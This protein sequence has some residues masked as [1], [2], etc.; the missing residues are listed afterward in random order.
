[1]RSVRLLGLVSVVAVTASL[2]LA[3]PAWAIPG[4]TTGGHNPCASGV[5]GLAAGFCL[6][7]SE[8]V[9]E[10]GTKNCP[11]FRDGR[12]WQDTTDL[13]NVP[14]RWTY[15]NGN[16]PCLRVDYQ[17]V[18]TYDVC[19]FVFY[20]PWGPTAKSST[21]LVVFHWQTV[22]GT[23]HTSTVNEA[24]VR[25]WQTAFTSGMAV[26]AIYFTDA[27]GRGP[28]TSEEIAWNRG[29][30]SVPASSYGIWQFCEQA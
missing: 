17:P 11:A 12:Q 3:T 28:T 6:A 25:G 7:P 27:N 22:D 14:E 24:P 10:T 5:D 20:V 2:L 9:L 4:P 23:W 26:R 8:L 18:T 19:D 21:S 30:S 15:P 13:W 1:M 29:T 16:Y